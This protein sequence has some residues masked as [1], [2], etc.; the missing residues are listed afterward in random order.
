MEE[1]EK[2]SMRNK[3]QKKGPKRWWE[4]KEDHKGRVDKKLTREFLKNC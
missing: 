2:M 1:K 3:E 4:K